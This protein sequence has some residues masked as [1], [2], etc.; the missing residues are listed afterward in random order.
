MITLP[1]SIW[2]KYTDSI[3]CGED[4]LTVNRKYREQWTGKLPTR[5]VLCSNELPQL[6]DASMAIAGRFVDI[7]NFH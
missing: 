4:T 1:R 6:G 7:R 2:R 3:S 5:L